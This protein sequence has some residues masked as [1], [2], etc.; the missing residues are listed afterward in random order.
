MGERDRS[1]HFKHP[2]R[3][4]STGKR[5]KAETWLQGTIDEIAQC[6]LIIL[7]FP[8]GSRIE[9]PTFGSPDQ[10][11]EMVGVNLDIIKNAIETWEP[12][13][14]AVLDQHPDLLDQ[15]VADVLIQ[16]NAGPNSGE[17]SG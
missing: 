15:L 11:F 7:S 8:V 2:F 6:V 17:T 1:P 16:V 10:T 14:S 4:S 5:L 9:K 13:A 12:R 3:L